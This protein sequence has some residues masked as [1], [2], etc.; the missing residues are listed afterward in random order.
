MELPELITIVA[1]SSL[2]SALVTLGVD[3]RRRA[4]AS[5]QNNILLALR[6]AFLLE[7]YTVKS[8]SI[9]SDHDLAS[10]TDGHLGKHIGAVPDMPP[11]PDDDYRTFGQELLSQLLEF[12]QRIDMAKDEAAFCFDIDGNIEA[13]E[14]MRKNTASLAQ[15]ALDLSR[16]LRQEYKLPK[17]DLVIGKFDVAHVLDQ[18]IS[19][20]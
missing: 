3:A 18:L 4:R 11:L 20:D 19:E 10:Q 14:S 8:V 13:V 9:L 16:K 1:G 12:P 5:R 17:R 2:V 7:G 15:S 6:L